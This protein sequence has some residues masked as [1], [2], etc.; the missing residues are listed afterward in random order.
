MVLMMVMM[1][2][3]MARKS[4]RLTFVAF[5]VANNQKALL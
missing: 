5:G 4:W 1:I 2:M 3:M